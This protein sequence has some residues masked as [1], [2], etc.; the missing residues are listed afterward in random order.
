MFK[1]PRAGGRFTSLITGEEG[2]RRSQGSF[3]TLVTKTRTWARNAFC[4]LEVTSCLRD[5]AIET[6]E[7]AAHKP[8]AYRSKKAGKKNQQQKA[9][10]ILWQGLK[11]IPSQPP[12]RPA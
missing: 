10:Q 12:I 7:R 3:Q 2:A 5:F 6:G 4:Q 11:E 9:H 1:Q 8:G